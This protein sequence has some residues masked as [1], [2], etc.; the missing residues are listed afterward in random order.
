MNSF[1][2]DDEKVDYRQNPY[3]GMQTHMQNM[4]ILSGSFNAPLSLHP[5]QNM[6][7]QQNDF[8][9]NPNHFT[10]Y[11]TAYNDPLPNYTEMKYARDQAM[12]IWQ[13]YHPSGGLGNVTNDAIR[14]AHLTIPKDFNLDNLPKSADLIKA[15]DNDETIITHFPDALTAE[16]YRTAVRPPDS[17]RDTTIPTTAGALRAHVVTLVHAFNSWE[18]ADDNPGVLRPF[19][20]QVR[21]QKLVECKSYHIISSN[22]FRH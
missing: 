20:K 10:A 9:I 14:A 6:Q 21:D 2:P 16:F 7:L 22:Q 8:A 15:L 13:E 19:Q 4:P 3:A 11:G 17:V 1:L 5:M 18:H 12:H